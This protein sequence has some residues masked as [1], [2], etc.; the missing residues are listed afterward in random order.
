[1][2]AEFW[3]KEAPHFVFSCVVPLH[4]HPLFTCFRQAARLEYD[5]C[6][7]RMRRL[8]SRR[9]NGQKRRRDWSMAVDCG[10]KV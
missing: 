2:R 1:M 8:V 3:L 10:S 6:C 9:S 7:G 5:V 4:E